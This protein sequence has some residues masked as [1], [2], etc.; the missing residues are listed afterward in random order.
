MSTVKISQLPN[1]INLDANTSNTILIGVN[2]SS[3]VTSQFTIQ[4][5]SASLYANNTLNVG[6]IIFTDGTSQNTSSLSARVYANGA[7]IQ[8]NAAFL[9]ANTTSGVA[10]S[11]ALYANGA[12]IQANTPSSTANSA[13]LYANSAFIKAN[14]P[15]AIANS[16]ALYAN[17]AFIQA[18]TPPAIANSAAL[19]ANG[20]FVQANA[21]FIKANNALANTTGLLAGNLTVTGTTTA[22]KGFVYTTKVFPGAQTAITIDITNDSVVRAQTAA[23]LTVTVSN[24]LSGKEVSLWITNTSGSNQTFTHGLPAIQSTANA[25]TYAIPSTSTICAKYMCFDETS[26]NSFVSIIHA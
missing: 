15:P 17:A 10:N 13:A 16:A 25:T 4:T 12:F 23:G 18:N 8:S 22:Q 1:L 24:L 2:V 21:A 20:S 5:L 14:T 6:N 11:A 19:Y 9:Q 26:Q 3:C 7:F